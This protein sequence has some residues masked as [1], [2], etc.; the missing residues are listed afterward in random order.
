[1]MACVTYLSGKT[2]YLLAVWT[3]EKIRPFPASVVQNVQE[4]TKQA[5]AKTTQS[6]P[7]MYTRTLQGA[8]SCH[9][10]VS[11]THIYTCAHAQIDRC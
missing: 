5:S 9:N 2:V 6:G 7:N 3:V 4:H 11:T 10:T 8:P 1:M